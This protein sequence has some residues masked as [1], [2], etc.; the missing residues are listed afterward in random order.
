VEGRLELGT[1]VDEETGF[2][3]LI[4]IY[5]TKLSETEK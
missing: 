1:K 4:R 2:V 5:A 3:S